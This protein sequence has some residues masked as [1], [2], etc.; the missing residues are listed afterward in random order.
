M[1][2]KLLGP[3]LAVLVLTFGA[4]G[5]SPAGCNVTQCMTVQFNGT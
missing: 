4:E 2:L 3:T 1:L 5:Y